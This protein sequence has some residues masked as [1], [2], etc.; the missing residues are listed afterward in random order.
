MGVRRLRH[1]PLID[2][3]VVVSVRSPRCRQLACNAL[4]DRHQ[5]HAQGLP[6][7][8]VRS[9]CDG[10]PFVGHSAARLCTDRSCLLSN[11]CVHPSSSTWRP[12]A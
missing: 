6:R 10:S 1:R 4:T 11:V 12:A 2:R 9:A 7:A 8:T 3:L 5:G